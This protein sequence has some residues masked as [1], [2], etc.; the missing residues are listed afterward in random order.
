MKQN[1]FTKTY[2][3]A[4]TATRRGCLDKFEN[5]WTKNKDLIETIH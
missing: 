3:Q 1:Y 4:R 2:M 5:T